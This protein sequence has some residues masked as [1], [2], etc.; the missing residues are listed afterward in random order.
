MT[1]GTESFLRSL[2]KAELKPVYLI[3]GP[4][5]LLVQECCDAL[6][7][8]LRGDGYSE[9]IVIETDDGG[10]SWDELQLSLIHI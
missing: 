9:R 4:E 8:R 7:S 2:A 3:A 5:A 6:R 10:F 1:V